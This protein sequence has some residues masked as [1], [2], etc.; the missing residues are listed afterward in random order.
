VLAAG[1]SPRDDKETKRMVRKIMCEV[2]GFILR[3]ETN[4]SE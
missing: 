3:A 4:K 2:L 1:G